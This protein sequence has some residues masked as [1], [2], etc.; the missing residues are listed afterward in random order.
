PGTRLNTASVTLIGPSQSSSVVSGPAS[1]KADDSALASP[2]AMASPSAGPAVRMPITQA[3][4]PSTRLVSG[5]TIATK[6]SVFGA[7]ASRASCVTPPNKN[8]VMPRTRMPNP[9]A[10][11]ACDNSCNSRDPKNNTAAQNAVVQTTT[12]DQLGCQLGNTPAPR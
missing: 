8:S 1:R 6:N 7:P 3:V 5:P 12:G 2:F 9:R 11:S 4:P 10:I